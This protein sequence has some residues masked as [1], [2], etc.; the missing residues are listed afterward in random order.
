LQDAS[1]K[2]VDRVVSILR[3]LSRADAHGISLSEICIAAELRK[4]TAHRIL[5]ALVESGLLFQDISTR[6]YRLGSAAAALGRSALEQDIAGAAG[7]SLVRIARR[8][9]DTVFASVREGTAAICVAREVGSFPIR[10]LT[11]DIGDR[12]PLGVGA[13]SLALLASIPD[14]TAKDIIDRNQAW[15][16]DFQRFSPAELWRLVE[17]TRKLGYALNEGRIVSGMS[18]IGVPVLDG[19]GE[20]IASLSI[21]AIKDRMGP[22]RIPELVQLLKDEARAIADM[23]RPVRMAAE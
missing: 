23:L 14:S 6:Y 9:C 1:V 20:L 13:G 17:R 3:I 12:R 21:A 11:L 18:A 16:A 8:C 2:T 7:H 19:R 15:L 4:T 10:T 22:E 5:G